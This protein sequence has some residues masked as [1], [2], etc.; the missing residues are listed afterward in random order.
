[1]HVE[2]RGKSLLQA[3]ARRRGAEGGAGGRRAAVAGVPVRSRG[4]GGRRALAVTPASE[5]APPR[6]RVPADG[7]RAING[8][9][10]GPSRRRRATA[11]GAEMRPPAHVRPSQ[12]RPGPPRA[13]GSA[14]PVSLWPDG[15]VLSR[16][17]AFF[18]L[19]H[20]VTYFQI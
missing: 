17:L 2:G 7:P 9:R 20:T 13:P 1:M 12:A 15:P 6:R 14:P 16:H 10:D 19:V 5:S 4:A 8:G 3:N 18:L 11:A